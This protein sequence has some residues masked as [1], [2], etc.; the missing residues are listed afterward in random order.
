MNPAILAVV[1]DDRLRAALGDVLS[2]RY[3][4]DY[5]VVIVEEPT[6]GLE[7]LRRLR[8]DQTE[9]AVLLAPLRMAGDGGIAFFDA[10]RRLHP[11]ARRIAIIDVG[12]VSAAGDLSQALT[13]GQLDMFFGQP[14]ASPEEELHPVVGDALRLWARDNQPRYE[15]ATIV[16]ASGALRGPRLRTWLERNTVATRLLTVDS[17]DG[18]GVLAKYHLAG[19]ELPVIVLYDGR[20]L[21]NPPDDELAEALGASTHPTQTHYDVAIVGG[22]PAGLAAAVY[23]ASDGLSTVLIEQEAFGGQAGTSSKIRNYLGFPWG[24]GGDELTERANRQAELF[25]AEYVVA[26]SVSGLSANGSDRVLTLSNGDTLA[27]RAVIIAAGVTY[28]RVNVP[29]VDNLV[30]AGV[31]YGA[32]VSQARSMGGLDVFV[33]GGGNSAGQAAVHL[34]Q[35]GAR[36]SV[37]IRGPTLAATMSD[38]LRREIAAADNILVVA[39]SEIID[40]GGPQRLERLVLGDRADGSTSDVKADALFIF[41]GAKPHTEWLGGTLAVDELGFLLTGPDLTQRQPSAWPLDRPPAWLETS[42]P[43]VFAAGDIRHG[44]TKRVAAAV[45]EGSSAAMLVGCQ[46]LR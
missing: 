32:A 45:G 3:G 27:A 41:I 36:V 31:F 22:G 37:V 20:V 6:D 15:K 28:R 25:G 43:R 10:A 13:L 40:A 11:T 39:N 9:V 35:A 14:W 1:P 46:Q 17:P 4:S 30:G 16:E 34:A 24:V 38:Y 21:V 2:R 19:D 33:L 8:D 23:A 5:S 44:S 18:R 26:R 29:A 12:D 42:V 7:R